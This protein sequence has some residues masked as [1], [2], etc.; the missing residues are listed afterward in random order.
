MEGGWK[1]YFSSSI[2]AL[3]HTLL[4]VQLIKGVKIVGAPV[5]RTPLSARF[6]IQTICFPERSVYFP[7]QQ[8]RSLLLRICNFSI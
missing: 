6:I 5:I 1:A 4:R 8:M 3:K 7:L 2:Q